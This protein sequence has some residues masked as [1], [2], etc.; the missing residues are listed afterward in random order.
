MSLTRGTIHI[1]NENDVDARLILECNFP[2]TSK[3]LLMSV[4]KN[5][6]SNYFNEIMELF[7]I[8]WNKA[9]TPE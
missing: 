5:K 3:R 8:I 7:E 9:R 2:F 6:D 4:N 1:I